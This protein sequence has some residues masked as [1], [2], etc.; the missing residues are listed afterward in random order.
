MLE[1]KKDFGIDVHALVTV[2]DIREYLTT[3]PGNEE[4]IAAMDE[5]MKQ[6]CIL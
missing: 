4:H 5:Y 6:Y 1:V 3:Q 2:A